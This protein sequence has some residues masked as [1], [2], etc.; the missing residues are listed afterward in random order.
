LHPK[1]HKSFLQQ[2]FHIKRAERG[3]LTVS[4]VKEYQ[5]EKVARFSVKVYQRKRQRVSVKNI[6][7]P[8]Q[9]NIKEASIKVNK[10]AQS[11]QSPPDHN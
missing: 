8:K 6:S 4:S 5:R 2:L 9:Q 7:N 10:A 11:H 3:D 1:G